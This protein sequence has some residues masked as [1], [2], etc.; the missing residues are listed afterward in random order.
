MTSKA[1][2]AKELQARR[3]ARDS[4][5]SFTEYTLP[6][7][8]SGRHHAQIA[9]ALERV[10]RGECKRLMIFA[11]PRHTKSELSS[12]RFPAWY[13]G[14]NPSK[15][16]IA[17]TYGHDLASDFGRDVRNII[18]SGE[19]SKVFK[20]ELRA[21]SQ[22][23]NRWHTDADGVYVATGVGGSITG[24][25]AN[26][27]PAGTM[28]S[29]SCGSVDIADIERGML[30][31]TCNPG[32]DTIK[33]RKVLA[34]RCSS[35]DR[36]IEIRTTTGKLVRATPDHP[37]YISGM[38][39]VEAG[40]LQKGY[41]VSLLESAVSLP[42]MQKG[43][44]KRLC[45]SQKGNK[46][47][48]F[49]YGLLTGMQRYFSKVIARKEVQNLRRIV[50]RDKVKGSGILFDSLHTIKENLGGYHLQSLRKGVS[51]PFSLHPI[52]QQRVFKRGA[53]KKDARQGKLQLFARYGIQHV[54]S[55]VKGSCEKE[56]WGGVLNMLIQ[57][58]VGSP[59]HR[60]RQAQQQIRES[61]NG[62]QFLPH[63]ASQISEDTISSVKE[64][65]CGSVCVYDIQVEETSCFFAGEIL[66]HNCA[67]IDDPFKN[68]EDAD[69]EL[70]RETVWNWY[71]STLYT[72]LMPGGAIILIMTRWH[73]DD[74][75]GRLLEAQKNGG[76][77]WE[78]ID[79]KAISNEG[80]PNEAALWPE[81][82]DLEYLKQ[83]KKVVGPRDWSALYQ[84]SP[85]ADEGTFFKREWFNRYSLGE[86]PK[87][88]KYQSTDFAVTDGG[89]DYTELGIIGL[90]ADMDLWVEDW[91]SGQESSDVWVNAMLDQIEKHSPLCSFGETGVIRRAVE[92][93]FRMFGKQ[94]RVYPRI[95][96]IT[97]KGDKAAIARALQG[98]AANGK[99][100]IP[101]TEWGDR[102]IEQLVAFP[103]GKHDDA[104]DVLALFALAVQTANPSILVD[105][106]TKSNDTDAW[107]RFK[108]SGSDSW[109]I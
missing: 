42:S 50:S 52:L 11:P 71:T 20:T 35:A 44:S 78:V 60:P 10:E 37:I 80:Q 100:H 89:G 65:S 59:S 99:V 74:L 70:K 72:R 56:G 92:P 38:G 34:T 31:S 32:S 1:D 77:Q 29:T 14:R 30:V 7:F 95:E 4:L 94:R 24:R 85:T 41:K 66:V 86:Q 83:V 46:E 107:G 76:D 87:T 101:R 47:G 102:L 45:G 40:K 106:S 64:V 54:F 48:A 28:V 21:D 5:L 104:V 26:C 2:A 22:S 18:K 84:Q 96:W 73:E 8:E 93:L 15:Q 61:D 53:F 3:R 105:I 79:L 98:M 75:A 36:L 55:A 109:R 13:L 62:V 12:R 27:F 68:R 39:W 90:C 63:N 82:Y 6:T 17:T 19:Y 43:F 9:D 69:S 57:K 25:G 16:I 51:P 103:A 108:R 67:L 97:R 58:Q 88:N 81:W 49:K 33:Y 91:W 23:A